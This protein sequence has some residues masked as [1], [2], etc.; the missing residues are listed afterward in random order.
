MES[1]QESLMM[2]GLPTTTEQP[3]IPKLENSKGSALW[4]FCLKKPMRRDGC[5]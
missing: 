3:G 1:Q 4:R 2:T 5:L